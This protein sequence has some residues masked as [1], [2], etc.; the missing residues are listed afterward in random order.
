VV[1]TDQPKIHSVEARTLPYKPWRE[2]QAA[3]PEWAT[4]RYQS[5]RRPVMVRIDGGRHTLGDAEN[6]DDLS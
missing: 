2:E 1:V 4:R 5:R 3:P 6:A